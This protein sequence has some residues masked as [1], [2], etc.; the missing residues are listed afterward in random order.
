MIFSSRRGITFLQPHGS[1]DAAL[2][3]WR[4]RCL[5]LLV[6]GFGLVK[7]LS[8]ME[9]MYLLCMQL[10]TQPMERQ[11]YEHEFKLRACKGSRFFYNERGIDILH[12][13]E[14]EDASLCCWYGIC[15]GLLVLRFGPLK[16]LGLMESLKRFKG[17]RSAKN[18][19]KKRKVHQDGRGMPKTCQGVRMVPFGYAMAQ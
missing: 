5:G 6:L 3:H 9:R 17:L 11:K 19:S 16:A 13:H 15:L 14:H 7:A 1:E 10:H 12:P 2:R 18:L 8:L 4:R